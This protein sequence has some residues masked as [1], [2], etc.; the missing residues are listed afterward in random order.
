MTDEFKVSSKTITVAGRKL[1]VHKST[2]EAQLKRFT[3]MESAEQSMNG[4]GVPQEGEGLEAIVRRGFTRVTYPSLT[5]CTSGKVFTEDECYRIESDELEKWLTT[6]RGMNPSWFPAAAEM[7][8]R[9]SKKKN[10]GI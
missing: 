4:N 3:L 1:T 6:A 10:S 7:R 5:A 2:F 9:Q 8:K